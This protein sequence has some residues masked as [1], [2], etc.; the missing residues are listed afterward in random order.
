M[1]TLRLRDVEGAFVSATTLVM[2]GE[3]DTVDISGA[4]IHL[5]FAAP[6][7]LT[8]QRGTMWTRIGRLV[9]AKPCEF[10]VVGAGDNL[11]I[12]QTIALEGG[13]TVKEWPPLLLGAG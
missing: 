11:H 4:M 1:P 12:I 5:S 13:D 6:T 2:L 10:P 7:A 9:W 8:E 3:P